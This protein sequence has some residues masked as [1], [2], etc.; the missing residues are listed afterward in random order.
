VANIEPSS[1]ACQRHLERSWGRVRA[2]AEALLEHEH[3]SR[4]A[5]YTIQL[6]EG[7]ATLLEWTAHSDNSRVSDGA[8]SFFILDGLVVAQTIH[9]IV[10]SLE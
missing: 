2:L 3:L 4:E 10:E 1:K 8:D 5:E 9:Y 6:V 7:D